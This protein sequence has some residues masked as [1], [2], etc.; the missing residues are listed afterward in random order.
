MFN[1]K[2][3]SSS[4][5]PHGLQYTRVPGPSLFAGVC[6]S[7]CPLNWWC[8]PAI[9]S[10]VTLF[11]CLDLSWY[12]S[13][14]Q[15]VSS[16]HQVARVLEL[17]LQPSVFSKSIQGW[18][19]L[20]LTGLNSSGVFS[21]TTIWKPQFFSTLPFLWS[22]LTS[23]RDY[24]K[25]HSFD[26]MDLCPKMMSLLFNTLSRFVIAFLPRINHLQF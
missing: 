5:W 15:W 6:P 13:L 25:D 11:F 1:R 26:N 16:L 8:L 24:W 23:I 20:R 17:Q 9:S 14:F 3:M 19:P 22:A 12:P 2:V 10:S 7:P 21:S 18:F 4:S